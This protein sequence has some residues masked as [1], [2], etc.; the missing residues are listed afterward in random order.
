ML[1]VI[2]DRI[3]PG[4]IDDDRAIVPQRFLQTGM[5]VVPEGPRLNDRKL[6]DEGLPRLDPREADAWHAVHLER[7]QQAVPVDRGVFVQRVGHG[8]AGIL[9]LP[10]PEHRRG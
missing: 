4:R 1:P 7:Q 10:K 6:I 2:T 5:A 9:T 8:Q 3:R